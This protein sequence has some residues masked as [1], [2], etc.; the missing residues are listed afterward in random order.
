MAPNQFS[1]KT[2]EQLKF[3]VYLYIDPRDDSVFYV[4]KGN[5]NRCFSHL[6]DK[7]ETAKVRY[8]EELHKL[9]LS[10]RIEVLRHGISAEE[11]LQ[12]ESAAID[13]LGLHQLTNRV[14]GHGSSANGRAGVEELSATLDARDVQVTPPSILINI[15]KNFFHGMSVH[16]IYDATR[17]AWNVNPER[18][19]PDFAMSV[20]RGVVRE[21]FEIHAW[22]PGGTT[23]KIADTEGRAIPRL[24]RW[25]FVGQVAPQTVRKLYL[26]RSVAHY[27]KPGSQNPIR[28]LNC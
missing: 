6:K 25:E 27:S 23:L 21:V 19:S 24:S 22:V 2:R 10:P 11:A 28:Y 12:A 18:H 13:L 16:E 1:P 7:S 15:N 14:R 3:Y 26:G 4:G 20:F 5:N 9:G 17:S 8:I